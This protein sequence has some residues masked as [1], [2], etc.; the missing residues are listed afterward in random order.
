M[1]AVVIAVLVC[2]SVL[3]F[4]VN[5]VASGNQA[6]GSGPSNRDYV[7]I[8]TVALSHSAATRTAGAST[9]SYTEHCGGPGTIHRNADNVI[10][11]PRISDGAMHVHDYVGNLS[12]NAFSTD[13]S[14]AAAGTTCAN[15]DR[16]TFYWPVLRIL[17]GQGQD[18]VFGNMGRILEPAKV[19]IRFVGSPVTH[20]VEMPEFLRATVGDAKE[21]T[22]PRAPS[23]PR[24]TCT[25]YTDRI[26]DLYPV[27]PQGSQ[28]V[29]IFEF[30]NCWNGTSLSSA[31]HY[32]HVVP[33]T[34][35][36]VCQQGTF[37]IAQ[38][39]ITL[40]YDVPFGARYANDTFPDQ[41]RSPLVDH[42]DYI[43]VMTDEEQ[44][45]IVACVNSGR[46][47]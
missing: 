33:A 20:V 15:G 10:F 30:P 27:C 37:P 26:T 47:C 14:L 11:T 1:L 23:L 9:G 43:D 3:T 22:E 5:R 17:D 38:L 18:M 8:T 28:V 44:A 35:G 24:W 42:A 19:D 46:N 7:D 2:V 4:V 41:L 40:T 25:G 39:R 6:D 31:D 21:L 32:T 34:V 12:T 13:D 16:S 36:G 29:R 45:Q